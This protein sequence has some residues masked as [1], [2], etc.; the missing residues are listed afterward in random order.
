MYTEIRLCSLNLV[1]QA[2]RSVWYIF[3]KRHKKKTQIM[4]LQHTIFRRESFTQLH[5]KTLTK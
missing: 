4:N 5:T 1:I 2:D 3:T